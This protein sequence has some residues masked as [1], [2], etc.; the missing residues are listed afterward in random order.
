MRWP[1]TPQ[2]LL[3]TLQS[4]ETSEA[5]SRFAARYGEV[6]LNYCI[7][8]GMQYADAEDIVQRVLID[9]SQ[10]MHR[11]QF[12][13]ERGRFRCWLATVTNRAIWRHRK[14]KAPK[15]ERPLEE[16]TDLA[17]PTN[18]AWRREF[19]SAIV[20]VGLQRIRAEFTAEEW[21]AFDQNWRTGKRPT[22]IAAELNRPVGWIYQVKFKVLQRL[23]R[24]VS[25]L[26]D[27]DSW[28]PES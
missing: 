7:R 13:A 28:P 17:Q 25:V 14:R 20:D 6:L 15:D 3:A 23:K 4:A 5:W 12:D 9:V 11:F 19:S 10:Q 2:A 8:R 1:T 26:F 21:G 27:D 24:E 16:F 18:D 22:E